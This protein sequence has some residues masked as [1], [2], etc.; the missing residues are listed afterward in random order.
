MVKLYVDFGGYSAIEKGNLIIQKEN[1]LNKEDF[2][3]AELGE[4]VDI[5]SKRGKFLGRGFKNPHEVRIMT[6][7]M[8]ELDENYIR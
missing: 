7:K 2:E 3:S 4:V 1:I 5:Y 6:L 8:E